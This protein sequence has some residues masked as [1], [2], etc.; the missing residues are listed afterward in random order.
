MKYESECERERSCWT[1]SFVSTLRVFGRAHRTGW[2]TI[3]W[4]TYFT[5]AF[6]HRKRNKNIKDKRCAVQVHTSQINACWWLLPYGASMRAVIAVAATK[7]QWSHKQTERTYVHCTS[8]AFVWTNN[9]Q[10]DWN[11]LSWWDETCVLTTNS[12]NFNYLTRS[13]RSLVCLHLSLFNRKTY[14]QQ[15]N[16]GTLPSSCIEWLIFW[17]LR[18]INL[19]RNECTTEGR[20][21][22]KWRRLHGYLI[23]QVV[24]KQ[25]NPPI[26]QQQFEWKKVWATMMK[27]VHFICFFRL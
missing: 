16:A 8:T 14:R 21:Y 15:Q 7:S 13:L 12:L 6:T 2:R 3:T 20:L 19:K 24:S 11:I 1:M 17:C 27:S 18:R 9:K 4:S 26:L 10:I 5:R 25:N 23:C 22:T